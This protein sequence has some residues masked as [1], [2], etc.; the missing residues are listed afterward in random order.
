M[1]AALVTAPQPHGDGDDFNSQD[2]PKGGQLGWVGGQPLQ[3]IPSPGL[4]P[5]TPA[6]VALWD[7]VGQ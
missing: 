3:E 5:W 7:Y 1:T 4:D 6:G 2:S